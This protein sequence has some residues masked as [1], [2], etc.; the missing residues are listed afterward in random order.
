M[1]RSTRLTSGASNPFLPYLWA[2]TALVEGLEEAG[3]TA[4]PG[5]RMAC[6]PPSTWRSAKMSPS[7]ARSERNSEP[8]AT[9]SSGSRRADVLA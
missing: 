5:L 3:S 1:P 8:W 9:S 7:I 2:I 6:L 4:A